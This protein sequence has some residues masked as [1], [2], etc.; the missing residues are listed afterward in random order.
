LEGLRK[1]LRKICW[2][3]GHWANI[4][5]WSFGIKSRGA[6]YFTAI[7]VV[8]LGYCDMSVTDILIFSAL[9]SLQF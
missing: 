9:G 3:S 1:L 4:R 7:F 5:Y 6:I 2:R 8:V